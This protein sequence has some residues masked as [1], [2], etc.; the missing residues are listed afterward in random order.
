MDVIKFFFFRIPMAR[1][2][3]SQRMRDLSTAGRTGYLATLSRED[4]DSEKKIDDARFCCQHFISD[5]PADL[6]D[7]IDD[8]RVCSRLFISGKP[9]D[10]MDEL[11]PDWP[12]TQNLGNRQTDPHNVA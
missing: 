9:A 7:E 1:T 8:A 4:L 10:L 12:P 2:I 11:N 3:V 6:L 5:K